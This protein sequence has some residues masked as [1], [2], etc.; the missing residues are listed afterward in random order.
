MTTT[1]DRVKTMMTALELDQPGFAAVAGTTKSVVNQW[2]TGKIKSIA[3]TYAYAIAKKTTFYPEWI[4]LGSGNSRSDEKKQPNPSSTV[5]LKPKTNR[6]KLLEELAERAD[7]LNDTGI[8]MLVGEAKIFAELHP[9][10][11]SETAKSSQ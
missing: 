2:L 8:A 7:R 4:M 10:P 6:D 1:I 5:T 3:P 11:F 9:L